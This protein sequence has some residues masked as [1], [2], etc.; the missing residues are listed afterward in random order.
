MAKFTI[1]LAFRKALESDGIHLKFC[2]AGLV[3][4]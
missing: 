3:D 1:A 4:G 2:E